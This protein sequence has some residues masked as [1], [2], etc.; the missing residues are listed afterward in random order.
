MFTD[1]RLPSKRRAIDQ[2]KYV[3]FPRNLPDINIFP[4]VMLYTQ[5]KLDSFDGSSGP[6][7]NLVSVDI[8]AGRVIALEEG[9]SSELFLL[10]I[11]LVHPKPKP[12]C[13]LPLLEELDSS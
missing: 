1:L 9:V 5:R 2:A 4:C 8:A 11:G 12:F 3:V 7:E 6:A 13:G 10:A